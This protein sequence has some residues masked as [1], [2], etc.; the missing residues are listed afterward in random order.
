[1]QRPQRAQRSK[2]RKA[3]SRGRPKQVWFF[4]ASYSVF[5]VPSVVNPLTTNREARMSDQAPT[6]AQNDLEAIKRVQSAFKEIKK[7]LGRVIVGQDHVIEELLIALF[8]R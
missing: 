6:L 3:R 2:Q 8:S 5:S 4:S 1:P 7:Q